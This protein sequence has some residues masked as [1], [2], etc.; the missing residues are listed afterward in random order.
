MFYNAL[1]SIFQ[2]SFIVSQKFNKMVSPK[3]LLYQFLVRSVEYNKT[4]SEAIVESIKTGEESFKDRAIKEEE[5]VE[6]MENSLKL[7]EKEGKNIKD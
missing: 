2:T 5:L 1:F 4:Q 3:M 6:Q 7:L